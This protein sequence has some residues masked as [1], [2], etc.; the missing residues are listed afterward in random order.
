[1]VTVNFGPADATITSQTGD[2]VVLPTWGFLVEGPTFRAIYAKKWNSQTCPE[3]ALLTWQDMDGK[4]LHSKGARIRVYHGFGDP[5]NVRD[6][7][8]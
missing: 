7:T 5:Q 8:F 6:T 1:M 3:G 4:D 2:N